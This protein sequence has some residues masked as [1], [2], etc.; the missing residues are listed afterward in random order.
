MKQHIN[1]EQ[2]VP[3]DAEII[4]DIR[5]RAW[6]EAYP[7]DELGITADDIRL[8]A[9][10]LDGVFVPR[11]IAYIQEKLSKSERADNDTFVAKFESK[12]VG[13]VEPIIEDGKRFISAIYVDPNFQGMG[14]GS[15]LLQRALDWHGKDEDIYLEVVAYNQKAI[16]FYERFGFEKTNTIVADEEEKPKY[17]TSLPQI[18][19][20]LKSKI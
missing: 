11:R 13:Y 7:N 16:R 12:V 1:I 17:M 2:A 14:I 5:D 15:K 19:M 9:Q 4:C 6:I 10:G 3:N 8:N 18:E 20:V